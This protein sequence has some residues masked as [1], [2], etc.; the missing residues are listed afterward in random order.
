MADESFGQIGI[1][2]QVGKGHFRFDHPEF[3]RVARSVGIFGPECGAKGVDIRKRHGEQFSFQ[4]AADGQA[5][6]P[7][8]KVLTEVGPAIQ[9]GRG[10]GIQS[11]DPEQFAGSLAVAGGDDRGMHVQEVVVA[12]KTVY[13]LSHTRPQT[14]DRAEGVAACP[15]VG[16]VAQ[17]FKAVPFFL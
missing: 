1:I 6:F 2:I 9:Q 3:S 15:Q 10:G 14:E 11:A 17:V 4:L 7:S 13:G 16:Y 8:E 12:E 5:G